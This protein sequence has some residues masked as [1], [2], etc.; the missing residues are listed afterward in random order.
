LN[1]TK[2]N[3]NIIC[4]NI[5]RQYIH[6]T[7]LAINSALIIM[8]TVFIVLTSSACCIDVNELLKTTSEKMEE[9]ADKK[10]NEILEKY[11]RRI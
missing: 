7:R 10:I 6:L 8:L 2:N 3:K 5:I 11:R 9:D 1:I 4:Q